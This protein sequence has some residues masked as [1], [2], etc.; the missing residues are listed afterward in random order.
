MQHIPN[1]DLLAS[2]AAILVNPVNCV[3]V[4]GAGLA[5]QF[6][7]RWPMMFM[8]YLAFCRQGRLAPGVLHVWTGEGRTI[9]NLPT[10]RNWSDKSR[11]E[12]IEAGLD[13]LVR[14]MQTRPPTSIAVPALGAGLGGLPAPDVLG[15]IERALR[16][17]SRLGWSVYIYGSR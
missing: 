5:A 3:G 8:D 14:W 1:G 15:A 17:L 13:A 9:I 7:A 10:K 4:M 6:K 12:D 16:P 11:L 2:D